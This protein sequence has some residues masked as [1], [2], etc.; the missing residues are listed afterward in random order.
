M[1]SGDGQLVN[2]FWRETGAVLFTQTWGSDPLSQS[3]AA[4]ASAQSSRNLASLPAG[5]SVPETNGDSTTAAVWSLVQVFIQF[6]REV[7]GGNVQRLVFREPLQPGGKQRGFG[8]TPAGRASTQLRPIVIHLAHDALFVV[9]VAELL[10]P[11]ALQLQ[12]LKREIPGEHFAHELL[13]HFAAGQASFLREKELSSLHKPTASSTSRARLGNA[14]G[15]VN[16]EMPAEAEHELPSE[17]GSQNSGSESFE[18]L[19]SSGASYSSSSQADRA[20]KSE[21]LMMPV[22]TSEIT[23]EVNRILLSYRKG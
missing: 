10:P 23:E 22:D 7:E 6:A 1:A 19:N 4:R 2:V 16:L 8:A 20:P 3:I 17:Y 13:L 18:S 5:P 21:T 14:G 15:G 11:E 12:R 9:T